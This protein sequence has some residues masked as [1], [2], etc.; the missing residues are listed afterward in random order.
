MTSKQSKIIK[1]INYLEILSYF[2]VGLILIDAFI[3]RFKFMSSYQFQYFISPF[4]WL[5][6]ISLPFLKN[7]LKKHYK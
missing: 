7:F 1:V 2:L 6:F 5:L 3:Y 4:I